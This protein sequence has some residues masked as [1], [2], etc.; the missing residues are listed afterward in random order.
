M[1]AF[2]LVRRAARDHPTFWQTRDGRFSIIQR[3][4]GAW[5]VESGPGAHQ[6]ASSAYRVKHALAVETSPFRDPVPFSSREVAEAALAAAYRAEDPVQHEAAFLDHWP[7]VQVRFQ[8]PMSAFI[9]LSTGE[10]TA[11][12]CGPIGKIPPDSEVWDAEGQRRHTG[13]KAEQTMAI[14]NDGSIWWPA[15]DFR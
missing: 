2:E 11:V 1:G 10:V 6:A 5:T 7:Q 13:E 8:V 12:R 14:A 15:W 9:D 4:G 3:V